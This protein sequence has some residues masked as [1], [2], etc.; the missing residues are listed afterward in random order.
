MNLK[1][2]C[3]SK[4]VYPDLGLLI[5][6]LG[7]GLS[8]L[9][10]HGYGKLMGGPDTWTGL[11]SQM[12]NLGI[13]FL[14]VFWGF[15]AMFAEFFGSIFVILGIFYRPALLLLLGTMLVAAVRHL[16]LPAGSEGAGL[17]GAS[18]A[19]EFLVV[20]LGLFFAGPGKLSLMNFWKDDK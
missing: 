17:K 20:Y 4:K 18:H 3:N 10:L 11:G 1:S 2:L 9:V 6:R 7:F 5:V 15:M 19:L 12:Q 14:P 13:D 8:M 16:S